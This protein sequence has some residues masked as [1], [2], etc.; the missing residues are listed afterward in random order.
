MPA[1]IIASHLKAALGADVGVT[2]D[3]ADAPR[4]I[5]VY[6][7]DRLSEDF[8]ALAFQAL[9]DSA[10][11]AVA[12]IEAVLVSFETPVGRSRRRV[13][14]RPRGAGFAEGAAA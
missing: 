3:D 5:V 7:P 1:D 13:D 11:E 2:F 8:V 12:G 9:E 10:P 4:Q 14:I 6:R